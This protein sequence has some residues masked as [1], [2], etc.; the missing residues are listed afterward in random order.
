MPATLLDKLQLHLLP[1]PYAGPR[2][3]PVVMLLLNPGHDPRADIEQA[4]G[5]EFFNQ[6]RK[7]LS[8]ESRC[9]L[10]LLD[11]A[12]EGTIA[13]RWY[14]R[15]FRQLISDCGHGAVAARL[16]LLQFFPYRS[17]A[18]ADFPVLPS[19]A[20]TRG[21][22]FEAMSRQADII[23]ARSYKQWLS[24][25]PELAAYPCI[26]LHSV[27]SPYLTPGNMGAE[28]YRRVVNAIKGA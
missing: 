20:F 24:L 2:D 5:T 7:A 1:A 23:V 3:A 21:L 28:E 10:Y 11:P 22:L 26:M 9:P 15:R 6:Q 14:A 18:G 19:M 16:L 25:T 8:F 12:F 27:R 17:K 4:P 13:Y